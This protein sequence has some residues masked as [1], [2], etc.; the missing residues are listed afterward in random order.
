[1]RERARSAAAGLEKLLAPFVDEAERKALLTV[2]NAA[3]HL[4]ARQG[5]ALAELRRDGLL[6]DFRHIALMDVL[7]LFFD[8]QGKSERIKNFPFPRQ[9]AT[10]NHLAL[11]AFSLTLPLG[12]LDVVAQGHLAIWATVPFSCW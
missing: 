1:M 8:D 4:L 11:W 6:D 2:P 10:F 5:E 12:L 9:Y 3:T 7:K